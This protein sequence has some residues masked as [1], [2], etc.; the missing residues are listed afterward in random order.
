MGCLAA[1]LPVT[2]YAVLATVPGWGLV[3]V[4]AGDF[5]GRCG[6]AGAAAS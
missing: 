3:R 5:P 6:G 1:L 2:E 4:A